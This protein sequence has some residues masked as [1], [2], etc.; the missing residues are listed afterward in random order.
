MQQR[1]T[2]K[3][4]YQKQVNI[5]IEYINNNL[6]E[7]LDLNTLTEKTIFSPYHFH[8]IMKSFLGE[9]LGAFI[10]RIR[11]ETAAR[12]LRYTDL[13]VQDVAYQ[14]GY[15]IPSSLSKVFKLFY[16]VSPTEFR[17]NKNYTIM[18]PLLLSSELNLKAPKIRE[19]ESKQ[20]IYIQIFGKYSDIDFRGSWNL[21]WQ[22][23]KENKLFSAGIEHLCVY[24]D[25]PKVTEADKLRTDICLVIPKIA[26]TT[27]GVDDICVYRED[28]KTIKPKGEIGVK[29][30]KGGKFAVF[31]YQGPYDNMES[32]YN[33]IY[34]KWLLENDCKLRN[35]PGF[36]KYLNN[37]DRTSP[38]KLKTEIYIPIE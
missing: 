9:S 3:E 20:V 6:N 36:E 34:G 35:A 7:D 11:V 18:R 24:Y 31:S 37:P 16:N 19:I 14:V 8:R 10:M 5:I 28:N 15:D 29:E 12:L 4:E 21:L 26:K 2:T 1:T 22:Y 27:P 30:I 25:D 38:D 23:V 17:N 33:T 32:V 13:P